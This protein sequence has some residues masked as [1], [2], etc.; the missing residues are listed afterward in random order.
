M[1]NPFST[2]GQCHNSED[3]DRY[4]TMIGPML[5]MINPANWMNPQAYTNM[6]T[7][8]MDPPKP[9]RNGMRAGWRNTARCLAS[10]RSPS[11]NNKYLRQVLTRVT[12]RHRHQPQST[13][14]NSTVMMSQPHSDSAMAFLI[15]ILFSTSAAYAQQ[16]SPQAATDL[17]PHIQEELTPKPEL[18]PR[19]IEE[20]RKRREAVRRRQLLQSSRRPMPE[21]PAR[22]EAAHVQ[23]M[24]S[25][26]GMSMRELFNFMSHKIKVN[27]GITFD[28]VIEVN[29]DQGERGELQESG[30]Q[31]ALAGYR[32]YQRTAH[33]PPGDPPL[34]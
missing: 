8:P 14:N 11:N 18:G 9:T 32:C 1:L 2:C 25:V 29:G 33:A 26:S 5:M 27:E 12:G 17:P 7:V 15:L 23:P 31:H 21:H 34:L 22:A 28:E 4:N 24:A 13:S 20:F 10:R 3:M 16:T 6:M 30:A 19:L